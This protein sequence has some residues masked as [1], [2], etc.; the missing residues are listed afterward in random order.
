[1]GNYRDAVGLLLEAKHLH[2]STTSWINTSPRSIP[3]LPK[4]ISV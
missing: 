1:M 3:D 4:L 2:E